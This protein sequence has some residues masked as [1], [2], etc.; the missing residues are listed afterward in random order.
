MA[1]H[2]SWV[3]GNA[4]RPQEVGGDNVASPG[5]LRN[6][7][8]QAW[9]DVNG[10][11]QGPGVIY[12]GKQGHLVFF[13]FPIPT[14]VVIRD[15]RASLTTVF[16]MYK[17]EGGAMLEQIVVFDGALNKG[18]I[19]VNMGGGVFDGSDAQ[20]QPAGHPKLVGGSNRFQLPAPVPIFYG[21]GISA[22]IRFAP[23]GDESRVTFTAAGAD[24]QVP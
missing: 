3:H 13:H 2:A 14:P 9:T 20:Q 10:L 24:F 17:T 7:G 19:P 12:Q 4:A 6:V 1:L 23:H 22:G 11:P 18:T 21:V 5:P 16:V 8:G 15:A